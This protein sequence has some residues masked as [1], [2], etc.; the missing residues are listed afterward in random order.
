MVTRT[1]PQIDICTLEYRREIKIYFSMTT[2]T[3]NLHTK[4]V[5]NSVARLLTKANFK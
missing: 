5:W 3:T 1:Q 2:E 4:I